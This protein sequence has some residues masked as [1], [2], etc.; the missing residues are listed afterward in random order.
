VRRGLVTLFLLLAPAGQANAQE[1]YWSL[2]GVGQGK[3]VNSVEFG[4]YTASGEP[5]ARS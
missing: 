1:R 4:S 2:L 5:P 3:T